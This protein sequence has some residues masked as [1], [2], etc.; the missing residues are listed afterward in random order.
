MPP[1]STQT[2]PREITFKAAARCLQQFPI[3]EISALRGAAAVDT[4]AGIGAGDPID[5]KV[6]AGVTKMSESI[7]V[8]ELPAVAGTFGVTVGPAGAAPTP[9]G[10][11]VGTMMKNTDLAG[12]DYNITHHPAHTDAFVCESLCHA[13]AKCKAWT[14]VIRGAPAGSGDC[15]LKVRE[16]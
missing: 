6:P 11:P 16:W 14:Y 4:K 3:E 12:G 2:L 10:T 15:C 5:L 13:D 9:A 1:A 7:I 8:F